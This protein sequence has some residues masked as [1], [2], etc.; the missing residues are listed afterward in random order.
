M[1]VTKP[2]TYRLLSDLGVRNLTTIATLPA[3]VAIDIVQIDEAGQKVYGP[4]LL[5][6]RGWDLP[7]EPAARRD[8]TGG[9]M[10]AP[11]FITFTGADDCT[12]VEGMVALAARYPIEWGVLFSPKRQGVEP[13]YPLRPERFAHRGLR[14]AAHLCGGHARNALETPPFHLLPITLEVF[15]RVQINHPAPE[16]WATRAFQAWAQRPTI[17]QARTERAFHGG[18]S[19]ILWLFDRSGGTGTLPDS[20]PRHPGRLVGYAGGIGPENVLEVLDAIGATGP[21]WIDMESGVRTGDRF[22]L[23]L[24]RRVCEAV[25]A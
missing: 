15:E 24:C 5:D 16:T 17:I 11:E 8:G 21:Y 13:R 19:E 22:D 2:G 6:W 12:D 9:V 18:D 4:A 25:Y 7:V 10:R 1:I 20:W 23:E 3:G 14:L